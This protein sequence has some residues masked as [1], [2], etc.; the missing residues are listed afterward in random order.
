MLS[1]C[2]LLD[3]KHVIRASH[4][5]PILTWDSRA[6]GSNSADEDRRRREIEQEEEKAKDRGEP[7]TSSQTTQG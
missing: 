6:R 5:E 3:Y 1:L 4:R 2:N 7:A